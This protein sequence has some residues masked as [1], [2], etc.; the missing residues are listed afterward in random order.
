MPLA[1]SKSM[2]YSIFEHLRVFNIDKQNFNTIDAEWRHFKIFQ[3][4]QIMQAL[5]RCRG[6][7]LLWVLRWC[8]IQTIW[9]AT[10]AI[11]NV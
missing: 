4:L 9:N 2:H 11:R 6:V 8:Q 10:F 3:Q 5:N 1:I 7:C